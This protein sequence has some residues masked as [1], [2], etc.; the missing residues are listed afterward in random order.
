MKT[1]KSEE[2]SRKKMLFY[3]ISFGE[4]FEIFTRP[5]KIQSMEQGWKDVN[6]CK[7]M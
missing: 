4:S 2:M 3:A 5:L 6:F 1:A 7:L